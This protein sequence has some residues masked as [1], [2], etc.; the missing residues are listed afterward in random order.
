MDQ[1]EKKLRDEF[2]IKYVMIFE[3]V[4]VKLGNDQEMAQSK[5]NQRWEKN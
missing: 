5:R 1:N 4:K 2:N 3:I